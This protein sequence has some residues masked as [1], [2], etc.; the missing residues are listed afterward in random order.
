MERE[1]AIN[2]LK[3]L[4][5]KNL[6]DLAIKFDVTV[7]TKNKKVNKGWA[8]HVC[9]RYLNLPIN[10]SQSPD[11]GNWELKSIPLKYKKNNQLTFKETMAIT[12]IDPV[13]VKKNDF[14]NSHLLTKLKK[15][16]CVARTVGKDFS[17][18]TYIRDVVAFDLKGEIYQSV[19]EDYD[20][21]RECLLDNKRGFEKLTGKMGKFIQPRTKGPGHGSISRA[22]YARTLFLSKFI[23]L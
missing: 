6:H 11:F 8:G 7:V 21:V 14:E 18:P 13:N 12:M 16:V 1:E 5:G 22:F 4:V 10:S 3:K 20:I 15:F 9:E 2:K 17:E 19:K 23:K